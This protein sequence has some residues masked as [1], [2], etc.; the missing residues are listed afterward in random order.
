MRGLLKLMERTRTRTRTTVKMK[1]L[2]L[3]WPVFSG[4]QLCSTEHR[5]LVKI[6]HWN[7]CASFY[8][9]PSSSV[10]LRCA[11]PAPDPAVRQ[12]VSNHPL[13][14][15]VQICIVQTFD[16]CP[17]L[18]PAS[19]GSSGTAKRLANLRKS[20]IAV[21][22]SYLEC[23]VSFGDCA[24]ASLAFCESIMDYKNNSLPG[25]A[26]GRVFDV[27]GHLGRVSILTFQTP[28]HQKHFQI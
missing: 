18:G 20:S 15:C 13:N 9:L 5:N 4:L 12:G 10:V 24:F 14:S 19:C 2:R 22:R 3:Q 28:R 17:C 21:V 1:R 8:A 7:R 27:E 11:G 25:N 16:C 23:A 26:G 6:D